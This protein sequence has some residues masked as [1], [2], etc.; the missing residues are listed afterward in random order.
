[1]CQRSDIRQHFATTFLLYFSPAV[2]ISP[3]F[4]LLLLKNM[5]RIAW[6]EVCECNECQY[7]FLSTFWWIAWEPVF[8]GLFSCWWNLQCLTAIKWLILHERSSG[9]SS[10]SFM[11]GWVFAEA[12]KIVAWISL[13][14]K[15]HS[16]LDFC[17]CAIYFGCDLQEH[18][19]IRMSINLNCRL[20]IGAANLEC[21]RGASSSGYC[22]YWQ[23][24]Y[25]CRV[26]CWFFGH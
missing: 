21:H 15:D 17:I 20:L 14:V 4:W 2:F 9:W 23:H 19:C 24:Y 5:H 10:R 25:L 1:M 16:S 18:L 7:V 6:W 11:D 3:S 12:C 26:L 13:T 8:T 22:Y